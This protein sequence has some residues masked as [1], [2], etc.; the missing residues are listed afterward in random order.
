MRDN[1]ENLK[2]QET[3]KEEIQLSSENVFGVQELFTKKE[4]NNDKIDLDALYAPDPD[5]PWWNK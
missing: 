1:E 5:E 3:I 4:V 2:K